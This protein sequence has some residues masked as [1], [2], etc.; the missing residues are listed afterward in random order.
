VGVDQRFG[1]RRGGK[2]IGLDQDAFF[3]A[4][5]CVHDLR[6]QLGVMP[7]SRVKQTVIS[8]ARAYGGQK[9]SRPKRR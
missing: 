2:A 6:V 1:D 9:T 7:Y 8:A 3:R 4:G 5:Q